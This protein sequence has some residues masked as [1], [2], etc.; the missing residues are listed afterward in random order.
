MKAKINFVLL[1][2]EFNFVVFKLKSLSA[3]DIGFLTWCSLLFLNCV[4]D[5]IGI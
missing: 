1:T 2:I 3:I 5:D 4:T